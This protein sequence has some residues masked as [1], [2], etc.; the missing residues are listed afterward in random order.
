MERDSSPSSHSTSSNKSRFKC[1]EKVDEDGDRSE[2]AV[3][4]C[5][6]DDV[7]TTI[8]TKHKKRRKGRHRNERLYV[9][10]YKVFDG[11]AMMAL[12]N[13]SSHFFC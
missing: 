7:G 3:S 2:E 4:E 1:A 10:M 12:G 5:D 13:Y 9:D 8:R 6:D 11:S